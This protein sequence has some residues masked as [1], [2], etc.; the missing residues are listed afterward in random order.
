MNSTDLS[1]LLRS[2]SGGASRRQFIA[3]LSGGVVPAASFGLA[4]DDAEAG[5]HGNRK[6]KRRNRK[7]KNRKNRTVERADATCNA[8]DEGFISGLDGSRL[9]QTFI[10]AASGQ[11]VRAEL[12]LEKLAGEDG[13]YV[14][15]VSPLDGSGVPT[16][17]VL[18]ETSAPNGVVPVGQSIVSFTFRTPFSVVANTEYALVLT[19]P[20]GDRFTWDVV[21]GDRCQGTSFLSGSGTGPFIEGNGDFIFTT[22]VKS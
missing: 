2:L 20:Q 14:L 7:R 9:A 1:L 5:K 13:D 16:N 3:A 11:L 19:V 6:K 8:A 17:E 15:R 10:A 18:A 22:F 21:F 4:F 12:L